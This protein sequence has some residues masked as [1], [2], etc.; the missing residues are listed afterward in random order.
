MCMFMYMGGPSEVFKP[1]FPYIIERGVPFS[2][3]G[4]FTDL[5]LDDPLFVLVNPDKAKEMLDKL[6]HEKDRE[7]KLKLR[8]AF[9]TAMRPEQ[10]RKLA[11]WYKV[12]DAAR[13]A[14]PAPAGPE[15]PREPAPKIVP[16][17]KGGEV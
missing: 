11:D 13:A 2:A 8:E 16:L 4:L 17:K 7:K 6:E 12:R 14:R 15:K 1:D 3:D 10:E 5:F 9:V